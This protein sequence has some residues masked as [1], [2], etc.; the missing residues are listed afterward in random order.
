MTEGSVTAFNVIKEFLAKSNC[1]PDY[2][3]VRIVVQLCINLAKKGP[4]QIAK[5]ISSG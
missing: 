3:N 5:L 4:E 1:T 2:Q